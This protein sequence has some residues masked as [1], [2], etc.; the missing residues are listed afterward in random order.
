MLTRTNSSAFTNVR[1][2]FSSLN[3]FLKYA[4]VALDG[5]FDNQIEPDVE[6]LQE[7]LANRF[8]LTCESLLMDMNLGDDQKFNVGPCCFE[9]NFIFPQV[10]PFFCSAALYDATIGKRVSET[11]YF[12]LNER[13][14]SVT[15]LQSNSITANT[16]P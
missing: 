8:L 5:A 3:Y 14:I 12:D 11:F 15:P 10:E 9:I 13:E 7:T 16:L 6:Y 1:V 4:D 2:L